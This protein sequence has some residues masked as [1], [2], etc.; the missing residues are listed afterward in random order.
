ML[1]QWFHMVR[2]LW[3]RRSSRSQFYC[4]ICSFE[5]KDEIYLI[6]MNFVRCKRNFEYCQPAILLWFSN[7]NL[8]FYSEQAVEYDFQSRIGHSREKCLC[9]VYLDSNIGAMSLK[10]IC[11]LIKCIVVA[12]PINSASSWTFCLRALPASTSARA[13]CVIDSQKYGIYF[14]VC[15]RNWPRHH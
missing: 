7:N 5:K 8:Y 4:H 11:Y 2:F 15:L 10:P 13:T 3:W 6:M 1:C 14:S 9:I 12:A